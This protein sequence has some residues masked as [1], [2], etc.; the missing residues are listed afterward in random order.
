MRCLSADPGSSWW[1]HPTYQIPFYNCPT[2]RR[3]TRP[4][5]NRIFKG[6]QREHKEMLLRNPE[7]FAGVFISVIR[8]ALADH[9]AD[10]LEFAIGDGMTPVDLEKLFPA[11][12]PFPQRELVEAGRAGPYQP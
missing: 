3:I 12:K 11:H 1:V 9:V 8:N 6:L 10:H 4:T 7:G 2:R 5:I